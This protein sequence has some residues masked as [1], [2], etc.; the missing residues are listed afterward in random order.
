MKEHRVSLFWPVILIGAGVLLLLRNLGYIQPFDINL[1]LRLWPLIL[2]VIGLD[3]IFGRKAS[4]VGGLIALLAIGAVIAFMFY[5]PSLGIVTTSGVRTETFSTPVEQTRHA[6]YRINASAAP[7][8]LD[9]TAAGTDLISATFTHKGIINYEVSGDKEKT[10]RVSQTQEVN[11][12]LQFDFDFSPQKWDIS[13]NPDVLSSLY[14]DGGSGA[15][16]MDLTGMNLDL[17]KADFGSG[18]ADLV[19]PVSATSYSAEIGSGSGAIKLDLP[20]NTSIDMTLE[21]GSGAVRISFPQGAAVQIEIMDEGSGAISVPDGF[22]ATFQSDNSDYS[23]WQSAGFDTAAQKI[24][25]R[26]LDRGSG[27]LTF[28]YN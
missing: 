26:V 16:N 12:W 18:A 4:W 2:V 27:A 22:T 6:E 23:S 9:A 17:L 13:L 24:T 20:K 19:L 10:I 11:A 7:V 1:L 25:I 14:F 15:I 5:S 28:K 8:E 3:L 21:S